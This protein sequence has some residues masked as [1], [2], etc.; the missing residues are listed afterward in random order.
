[1]KRL[2]CSIHRK[3]LHVLRYYLR[4]YSQLMSPFKSS[5]LIWPQSPE[6]ESTSLTRARCP[7]KG[8]TSQ[9]M[10]VIPSVQNLD[11]AFLTTCKTNSNVNTL[12]RKKTMLMG[13]ERNYTSGEEKGMYLRKPK[14]ILSSGNFSFRKYREKKRGRLLNGTARSFSKFLLRHSRNVAALVS[15][16]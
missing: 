8:A 16:L 13:W 2:Q 5:K 4:S 11:E 7:I 9:N 1:M 12:L 14:L 3:Y 15:S 6:L 10:R